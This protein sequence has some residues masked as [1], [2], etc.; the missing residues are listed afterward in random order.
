MLT[1]FTEM[2]DRLDRKQDMVLATII[3][4]TGS[5]PRGCG[6][7][8]LVTGEG[9]IAGTVGG[10]ATEDESINRAIALL[11]EKKCDIREYI[12][13]PSTDKSLN[14][15]CGG[16]VRILFRYISGT[17]T[18]WRNVAERVITLI[19]EKKQAWLVLGLNGAEPCVV[20][21][22]EIASDL[23]GGIT[24]DVFGEGC[25]LNDEY[26]SVKLPIG[27]RV[28]IFGG[29]HCAKALEP[30]LSSVGFRVTVMD[31]R[32]EF[33]TA[34]RFPLAE[35]VICGDYGHI[36]DYITL[37]EHDYVVIMTSGHTYDYAIEEQIL[38]SPLAYVGVL[39]SVHKKAAV[40]AKLK[41]AGILQDVIESVHTPIGTQI[42]AVTPEEI[43][44]S[45]V[46]EMIL[47]RADRRE[48]EG[49][50]THSCPLS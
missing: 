26:F 12:L 24:A 16:K 39:G 28:V 21:E 7:Q 47:A 31:S 1:L 46:G 23:H 25:T 29:G 19:N 20:E 35:K 5:A 22:Q 10:G 37:N 50:L 30:V 11:A 14:A 44:I 45:I 18:V 4:K 8:M 6:A 3:Y 13:F 49:E 9:R 36:S 34:D 33:A 43:A 40:A 38:R 48:A 41:E 27:E 32:P 2:I 17:D 15:V 42:K